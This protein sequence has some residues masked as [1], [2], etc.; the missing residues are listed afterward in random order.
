MNE[1]LPNGLEN[2]ENL[3]AGKD[4]FVGDSVSNTSHK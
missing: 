1:T 4:W 3:L 2:V